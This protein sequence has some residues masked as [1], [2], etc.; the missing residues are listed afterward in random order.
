MR[1]FLAVTM[2]A[3][4]CVLCLAACGAKYADSPYLGKWEATTGEAYGMEI[5]VDSVVDGGMSFDLQDDGTCKANV[6]GEKGDLDW[7][8][9]DE[10][11]K[12][13]DPD[14]DESFELKVDKDDKDHATM[15]YSGVTFNFERK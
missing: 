6:G 14:S 4:L 5:S 11:F 10:G 9:T 1:K 8:E 12:V 2:C 7:E 3:M 15:D 13:K